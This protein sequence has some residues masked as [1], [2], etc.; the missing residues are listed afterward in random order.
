MV[1]PKGFGLARKMAR[2]EGFDLVRWPRP[3]AVKQIAARKVKALRAS[4]VGFVRSWVGLALLALALLSR[5]ALAQPP[6]VAV[7]GDPPG[8]PARARLVEELESQGYEVI[9]ADR[10]EARVGLSARLIVRPRRIEV[11][12]VNRRAGGVERREAV[13]QLG[14]NDDDTA[15]AAIRAAEYLRASLIEV[16][17][18]APRKPVAVAGA[19][20]PPPPRPAPKKAEPPSS[21][22]HAGFGPGILYSTGGLA[23]VPTLEPSIGWRASS[24]GGARLNA[25][26]PLSSSSVTRDEGGVKLKATGFGL[27][28][29]WTPTRSRWVE[30]Y[31]DIGIHAFFLSMQGTASTGYVAED[32]SRV[33]GAV[34][35]GAGLALFPGRIRL[36]IAA[37]TGPA[38]QH[39][40]VK[41]MGDQA[42]RWGEWLVTG[43]AMV[44]VGMD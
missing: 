33:F 1:F 35:G 19:D 22:V 37:S 38:F 13:I 6:V 11:R 23:P 25:I 32:H 31:L 14:P 44:E 5:P 24:W 8:D 28:M 12:V 21:T 40:H 4:D 3:P 30:P 39:E 17:G 2:P 26:V 7:A 18:T 15:N 34:L 42:A 9:E 41:I 43:A 36:R 20:T 29:W 27:S 16:G 10:D